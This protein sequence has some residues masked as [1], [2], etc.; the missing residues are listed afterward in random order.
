MCCLNR[1]ELSAE[2]ARSTQSKWRL[3]KKHKKLPEAMGFEELSL[4]I[5]GG[6][7]LILSNYLE[8]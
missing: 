8:V 6:F 5:N 3:G 2:R 4:L 1:E 7:C